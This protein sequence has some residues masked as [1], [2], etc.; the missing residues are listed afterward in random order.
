MNDFLTSGTVIR[1]K[2]HEYCVLQLIGRSGTS[3]TYQVQCLTDRSIWVLKELRPLSELSDVEFMEIYQLFL[4]EANLLGTLS[5]PNIVKLGEFLVFES[6]PLF[7]MEFVAGKTLEIFLQ[8]TKTH[9]LEQ[10]AIN[11]GI[12]LARVLHYLHTHQPPIIYRDL[13]PNNIILTP[14]GVIKLIDFSIARIYKPGLQKDEIA[15]GTAGYA[16]PEQYGHA[17]TDARSDV[18]ALGATLLHLL[19][20]TQPVPLKIPSSGD[21]RKINTT[22]NAQVEDVIIK[23]MQLDRSFRYQSAAD[24]AQALIKCLCIDERYEI[25]FQKNSKMAEDFKDQFKHNH[26]LIKEYNKRLRVLELQ[27]A[28]F[29][30]YVP[31]HI[32]IEIDEITEKVRICEQVIEKIERVFVTKIPKES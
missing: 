23:A 27:A 30:L 11:Y 10:E 21:I 5:H 8:V 24:I 3:A 7:I 26:E 2:Q 20:G 4:Y 6:R 12:Q 32:P 18:Y 19:T 16:P 9:F 28:K 13:K 15:L 22:V 29:G 17:Q 1:G 31:P 14:E 25:I